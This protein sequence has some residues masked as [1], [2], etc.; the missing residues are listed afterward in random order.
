MSKQ[1]IS[2]ITDRVIEGMA[3]WQ[4]GP[5]DAVYP[6]IFIDAVNV[7]I[8]DGNVANRPIYIVLAVTV[9]GTRDI[10]GLWAGE[11]GD[12]EG[13]K[14]WMRV[15]RRSRTEGRRRVHGGVRRPERAARSDRN[16]MAASDHADM[17]AVG[18]ALASGPP[19]HNPSVRDYRTGLL[20]WILA[21]NRASGKGCRTRAGGS[22]FV[23]RRSI[24]FQFSRVRWLRRRSALNQCRLTWVRKAA[25]ASVLPGTA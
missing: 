24:R 13:S 7:K 11:H 23:M 20:P 4:S 3:E 22:H 19:H 14:F 21:S 15:L 9:E 2:T 5:L 6:V 1:T 8:R 18:T 12:G 16:R 25:T 10:L 17:I